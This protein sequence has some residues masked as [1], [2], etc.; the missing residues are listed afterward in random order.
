MISII[1]CSR[2]KKI[3]KDLTENIIKTVGCEYELIV[4]DNSEN[5][6]SIFEAY[7]LGIDQSKGDYLCLM[8]DDILIHTIGWGEIINSIFNND[9]QIG[10][11]GVA[12]AKIK[13]KSPSAWWDCPE[14]QKVINIIQHFPNKEKEKWKFGFENEQ[15]IEVVAIDGVFMAARK[16]DKIHFNENLKGFHN[17]DLNISFEYKKNGYKIIVA[18]EI[19]VEHFSLGNLN[20]AWVNSTFKI[21]TLYQTILP[22]KFPKSEIN[23]E[24]E[25]TNA[26]RFIN[27]SLKYKNNKVACSVWIQLFYIDPVSKYHI[28]F[29]KTIIKNYLK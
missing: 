29:W 4:I 25:I 18:D 15:I 10:L 13:T 1:I 6:Y 24:I 9:N 14:N 7:N 12:G 20:E 21:H 22:L 23:K 16:D 11:I 27:E 19:L 8:H 2:E 5:V 26:I 17:Y 3:S 28:R